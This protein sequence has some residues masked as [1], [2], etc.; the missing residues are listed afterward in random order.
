MPLERPSNN[1]FYRNAS[2]LC[3]QFAGVNE[4]ARICTKLAFACSVKSDPGL[5]GS[6]CLAVCVNP[7]CENSRKLISGMPS[8]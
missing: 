7:S 8:F 6:V 2:F 1:G 4:N 3:K 5:R